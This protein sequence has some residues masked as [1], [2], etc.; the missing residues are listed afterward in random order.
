VSLAGY[1]CARHD[2]INDR[3]PVAAKDVA[4]PAAARCVGL[5]GS[6]LIQDSVKP[7]GDNGRRAKEKAVGELKAPIGQRSVHLCIDMQQLFAED[8]PWPTPWMGRVL[9]VIIDLLERFASRTIFTRFVPPPRPDDTFGMWRAYYEKWDNATQVKLQPGLI[10]LVPPLQR[11]VPPAR[12]FDK[13]VYSAFAGGHLH[14]LLAESG[15]NTLVLSGAETDVCVLSTVLSAVDLGYRIIIVQD[16]LC[17]SADE[18]HDAL[19]QLYRHRF[20]LQI[21]LTTAEQLVEFWRL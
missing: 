14:A 12:I 10:D 17:S 3:L 15:I 13:P 11:F 6:E 16:A 1:Y 4:E 5:A 20:D 2:Q 9:P 8:G 21:E 18:G 19:L 7:K